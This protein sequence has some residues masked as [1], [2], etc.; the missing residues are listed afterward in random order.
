MNEAILAFVCLLLLTGI[1][2]TLQFIFSIPVPVLLMMAGMSLIYFA[3]TML[4]L[5]LHKDQ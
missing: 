5:K 4:R 3:H 1:L 2:C